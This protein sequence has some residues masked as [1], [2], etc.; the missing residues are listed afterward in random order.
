MENLMRPVRRDKGFT[1]V[2]L[3]ILIAIMGILSSMALSGFSGLTPRMR[4]KRAV[5]NIVSDMQTA[6]ARALR[7][8]TTWT[9]QFDAGN[10]RY[11]I[12]DGG[13]ATFKTSSRGKLVCRLSPAATFAS[14]TGM[15]TRLAFW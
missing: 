2:E 13:G 15:T 10:S 11:V 9:I 6:K 14:V 4:I 12:L 3:L 5:R 8:R 1:L 7:D